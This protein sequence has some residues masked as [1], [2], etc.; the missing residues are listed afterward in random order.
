MNSK[1]YYFALFM[2][3]WVAL[4][5]LAGGLVTSHQAGLAVPDWPLSYGQ[6]MPP[7]VGNVFWEHGHRMIAGMAGI[8]TVIMAVWTQIREKRSWFKKL[9][10]AAA[11]A[12]FLQA[13]LGGLTVLLMLPPAVSIFHATLAQT[14]FCLVAW[15]AYG[16]S[17]LFD[18]APIMEEKPRAVRLAAMTTVFIY[19]QLIL[20]AL[21]RHTRHYPQ[22]HILFAILVLIHM[23]LTANLLLNKAGSDPFLSRAALALGV[24]AVIQPVLGTGSWIYAHWLPQGYDPA[25]IRVFFT[26][27]HQ[28]TGALILALSFIT[29]VRL[30]KK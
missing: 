23:V 1:R 6:L 4:L 7:M 5:I 17:P 11:G 20:G 8:F 10:W 19:I 21:L 30:W 9:A 18:K 27:A 14:Y 22:P 13:L 25:L 12:V 3:C 24:F 28:T 29:T 16:L 15:M 2:T 26:A